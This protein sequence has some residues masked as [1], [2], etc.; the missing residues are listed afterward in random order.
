MIFSRVCFPF[1]THSI[2][3]ALLYICVMLF[4]SQNASI[5]QLKASKFV[6]SLIFVKN[7]VDVSF[8]ELKRYVSV[9]C[10]SSLAD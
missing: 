9:T 8:C 10:M 6:L 1:I 4:Q 3:T 5:P 2:Q 7:Q